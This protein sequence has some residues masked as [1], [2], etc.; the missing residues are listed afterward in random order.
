MTI[1]IKKNIKVLLKT[2]GVIAITL[3]AFQ[4]T[5]S[6]STALKIKKGSHIILIIAFFGY[7]ESFQGEKGL[8][9]Y[10]AELDAFIKHTLKQKYNGESPPQLAIVSPIA[11]EDISKKF[12]L[13]NGKQENAN[14]TLYTEAMTEFVDLIPTVFE[15]LGVD[16][17]AGVHGKSLVPM[18][19]R[20]TGKHKD[21]V[22]P[23][24]LVD[25]KA[26]VY[27]TKVCCIL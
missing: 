7:N 18:L 9:N 2:L 17:L 23:E 19:T 15:V 13:P 4:F 16:S 26:M 21:Y 3:C 20:E 1:S 22:L 5:Q 25:N 10:K 11:F 27:R 14:L 6:D 24:F 12:D 8:E